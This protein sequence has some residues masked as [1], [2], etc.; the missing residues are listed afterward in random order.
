MHR[1]A[2]RITGLSLLSRRPAGVWYN[3]P[4]A[5]MNDFPYGCTPLTA[6]V[7]SCRNLSYLPV[8]EPDIQAPNFARVRIFFEKR[9]RPVCC[10]YEPEG[11]S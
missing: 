10:N 4:F 11:A 9:Q 8:F 6:F 1:T 7:A 3:R 5:K 2:G